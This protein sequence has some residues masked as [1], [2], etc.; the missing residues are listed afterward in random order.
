MIHFDH[1]SYT[2]P[3]QQAQALTDINLHVGPG[4][5]ILVSGR[6][7]SGKSTLGRLINGLIPSYFSGTLIGKTQIAGLDSQNTPFHAMTAITGSLFQDPEQQ[8][9]STTVED[10]LRTAL[11]W[12]GYSEDKIRSRLGP[13]IARLG[14]EHKL[15]SSLFTL[16]EGENKR[17]RWQQC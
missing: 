10:E 1:V 5:A 9:L 11:E 4:E 13:I 14:L 7:G 12:R 2:Y 15:E 17:F 6:S 8:F 3:Y 16:S